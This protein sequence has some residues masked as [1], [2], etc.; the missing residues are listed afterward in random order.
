[1]AGRGSSR[2][3]GR[4]TQRCWIGCAR[5]AMAVRARLEAVADTHGP[6][7]GVVI[8]LRSLVGAAVHNSQRA[9]VLS[10]MEEKGWYELRL[11]ASEKRL[12]VRPENCRWQWI[13]WGCSTRTSGLRGPA[14]W[15][16]QSGRAEQR[17]SRSGMPARLW[18][19][20]TNGALTP[21][22]SQLSHPEGGGGES[23][24]PPSGRQRRGGWSP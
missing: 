19:H 5:C 2:R 6:F 15:R 24:R 1:M 12:S 8:V 9:A 23:G 10:F 21:R 22:V 16:Q 3:S 13:G 7:P 17:Q 20:S 18:T 4:A 11:I 14:L